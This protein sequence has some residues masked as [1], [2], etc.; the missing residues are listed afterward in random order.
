M[1][2]QMFQYAAGRSLS[3]RH[4]TGLVLDA[5]WFAL[6]DSDTTTTTRDFELAVFDLSHAAV[7]S[8]G[9]RKPDYD[10][11]DRQFT[12]NAAFEYAPDDT[13]LLGLW[14]SQQYFAHCAD[15]IRRDFTF[16][17]DI[18]ERNQRLLAQISADPSAVSLHVRRG[19]YLAPGDV[20]G[21]IGESYY[22]RAVAWI[23]HRVAQP[24][25]YVF[26]DDPSWCRQNLQLGDARVY[27]EGNTDANSYV[28]MWLMSRCKH[29]IIANST[30]S[31]WGAWL[32]PSAEKLVVAPACWF[33][34]PSLDARDVVP[35]TWT[36]L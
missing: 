7:W 14:Q 27:V 6:A 12:Y 9:M 34:D 19:D 11:R 8:P 2:N 20:T 16:R 1:G 32:N 4:R 15:V 36:Q 30:F 33:R 22:Q 3:L 18:S 35:S 5:Q 17:A 23:R 29:H 28:D 10:L 31:W 21:F 26:S 24:T 25:F 13:R